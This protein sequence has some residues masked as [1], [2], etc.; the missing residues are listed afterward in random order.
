LSSRTPHLESGPVPSPSL[1][2]RHSITGVTSFKAYVNDV[3][4]RRFVK[5]KNG[6]IF[7]NWTPIWEL[8]V[9]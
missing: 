6:H 8:D 7:Q 3:I 4:G 9:D 5:V 1:L 2:Q